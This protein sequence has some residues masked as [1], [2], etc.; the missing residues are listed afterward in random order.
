M[1]IESIQQLISYDPDTGVFTRKVD[2]YNRKAGSI[3]G[4]IQKNGY[5]SIS[6]KSKRYSAHRIAWLLTY[7]YVPFEIDHINHNK[8]D[9]RLCNL[10]EVTRQGNNRN[11]A[12][13]KHNKSGAVGVCRLTKRNSWLAFIHLNNKMVHLGERKD[14]NDALQLRKDA[15]LKYKFHPNHG[16]EASL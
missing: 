5:L 3:V 8:L 15:E 9:N 7:G 10:R 14:F 1:D 16:K 6:V 13:P 2:W 12:M 11:L 4:T